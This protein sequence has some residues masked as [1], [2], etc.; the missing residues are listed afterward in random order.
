MSFVASILSIEDNV[1]IQ[2]I[3]LP[4]GHLSLPGTFI[5]PDSND[6]VQ[7]TLD[8][9]KDSRSPTAL[10]LYPAL[11]GLGLAHISDADLTKVHLLLSHCGAHTMWN[12]LRDGQ[13]IVDREQIENIV[14]EF[15][16]RGAANRITPPEL[17]RWTSE[18]CGEVI[19]VDTVYP[20]STLQKLGKISDGE[21]PGAANFGFLVAICKLFRDYGFSR[22]YT[23]IG[24]NELMDST[25]R[26][27]EACHFRQWVTM[28]DRD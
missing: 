21:F 7:K 19:G 23:H 3:N 22:R 24:A 25:D 12:F 8:L 16:C 1:A 11:K 14:G 13:R 20:F 10:Q 5:S 6:A 28:N 26:K 9:P 2:L 4:S 17:T 27:T 18:F 15:A